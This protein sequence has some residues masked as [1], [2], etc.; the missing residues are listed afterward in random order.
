MQQSGGS[1][2]VRYA[3]LCS[4]ELEYRPQRDNCFIKQ[5]LTL[6]LRDFSIDCRSVPPLLG[7]GSSAGAA[8]LPPPATEPW[9][10]ACSRAARSRAMRRSAMAAR[11][12]EGLAKRLSCGSAASSSV[13]A[14]A[15]S[16]K[17]AGPLTPPRAS[18]A[19]SASAPTRLAS[20][21]P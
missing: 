3:V 16:G 12:S 15:A 5:G 7:A 8:A 1:V 6:V 20:E 2:G 21:G 18:V 19:A 11:F 9:L 4:G 10:S 13:S 17:A 14:C